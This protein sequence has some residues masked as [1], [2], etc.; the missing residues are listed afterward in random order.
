MFDGVPVTRRA[1]A[2]EGFQVRDVPSGSGFMALCKQ[3]LGLRLEQS[4]SEELGATFHDATLTDTTGKDR[5][6]TLV[7][8]IP[9]AGPGVRWLDDPRHSTEV[10]P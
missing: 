9:L 8:A 4:Q 5:A 7:Y 3:C 6:V 10:T 1:A 2:Q